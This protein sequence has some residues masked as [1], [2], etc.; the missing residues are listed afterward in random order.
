MT[1][2]LVSKIEAS[3]LAINFQK[4]YVSSVGISPCLEVE[5]ANWLNYSV[6][7]LLFKYLGLSLGGKKLSKIDWMAFVQEMSPRLWQL[8]KPN[9]LPFNGWLTLVNSFLTS[10]TLLY[11]AF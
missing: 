5:C 7:P 6:S 1:N 9:F 2:I 11:V 4:S 8:R 3:G 10:F